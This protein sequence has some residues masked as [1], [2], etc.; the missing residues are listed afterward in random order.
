MGKNLF[1]FLIYKKNTS[2]DYGIIEK[3]KSSVRASGGPARGT[4]RSK[5]KILGEECLLNYLELFCITDTIIIIFVCYHL[6]IMM[7][8]YNLFTDYLL[9]N[10]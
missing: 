6:L 8:L 3:R 7:L 10:Q 2:N 9:I 1:F 4:L 5:N